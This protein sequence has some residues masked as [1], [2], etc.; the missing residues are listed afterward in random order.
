M[1]KNISAILDASSSLKDVIS[2]HNE[3]VL[4]IDPDQQGDLTV[5]YI[6][7]KI[8]EA[9]QIPTFSVS[10]FKDPQRTIEYLIDEEIIHNTAEGLKIYWAFIGD[11]P[12]NWPSKRTEITPEID[13][14]ILQLTDQLS[15]SSFFLENDYFDWQDIHFTKDEKRKEWFNINGFPSSITQPRLPISVLKEPFSGDYK[16]LTTKK[17][18][19]DA[20]FHENMNWRKTRDYILERLTKLRTDK[21]QYQRNLEALERNDKTLRDNIVN[22][23]GRIFPPF[24]D[25]CLYTSI[26]HNPNYKP[27]LDKPDLTLRALT[28]AIEQNTIY[29]H[30]ELGKFNQL[31]KEECTLLEKYLQIQTR[32][33]LWIIRDRI[34]LVAWELMSSGAYED[35][36]MEILLR[37]QVDLP[38]YPPEAIAARKRTYQ[39]LDFCQCETETCSLIIHEKEKEKIP[40]K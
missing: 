31:K 17:Q 18:L 22:I 8:A 25:P 34:R 16:Y 40:R 11:A 2:P 23:S 19:E 13:N 36:K 20:Y 27:T 4:S 37:P 10:L 39:C 5:G 32:M 33:K 7:N 26:F 21:E 30:Q 24:P 1:S 35:E 15:T 12:S 38:P 3:L 9:H 14:V 28:S 6:K 29:Y